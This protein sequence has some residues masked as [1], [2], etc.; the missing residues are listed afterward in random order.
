VPGFA[1][2]AY[3]SALHHRRNIVSGQPVNSQGHD[4]APPVWR[5]AIRRRAST[6]AAL[7]D[8]QQLGPIAHTGVARVRRGPGL[9]EFAQRRQRR[10]TR[11]SLAR[12]AFLGDRVGAPLHKA[13][14]DTRLGSCR[15]Q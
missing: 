7:D 11:A 10:G 6:T 13:D 14:R 5:C 2:A 1:V 3:P 9:T 12:R 4:I 15:R 8:R